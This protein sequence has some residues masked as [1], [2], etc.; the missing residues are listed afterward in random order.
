MRRVVRK[1][2]HPVTFDPLLLPGEIDSTLASWVVFLAF[3]DPPN[4]L[5]PLGKGMPHT[6]LDPQLCPSS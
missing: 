6:A 5:R 1:V 3:R 2:A 4:A